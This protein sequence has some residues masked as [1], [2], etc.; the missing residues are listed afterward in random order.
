[1]TAEWIAVLVLAT[2]VTGCSKKESPPPP[3][4][5]DDSLEQQR[6]KFC[7]ELKTWGE[8]A[9]KLK[10]S[11][12]REREEKER[13]DRGGWV[14]IRPPTLGERS[15]PEGRIGYWAMVSEAQPGEPPKVNAAAAKVPLEELRKKVAK[16]AGVPVTSITAKLGDSAASLTVRAGTTSK[17]DDGRRVG[18]CSVGLLG[19]STIG[20]EEQLLA[21]GVRAVMCTGD[22]CGGVLNLRPDA[23]PISLTHGS[24]CVGIDDVLRAGLGLED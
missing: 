15:T 17:L 4:P 1:M 21:A 9:A 22:L 7:P 16:I 19:P 12:A 8:C 2:V 6:A 18:V 14:R 3:P 23:V 10:E 5:V 20:L 24:G 13:A 11:G